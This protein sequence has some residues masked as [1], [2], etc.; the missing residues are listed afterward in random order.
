MTRYMIQMPTMKTTAKKI[1]IKIKCKTEYSL[2]T[3]QCQHDPD[4]LLQREN[5]G[6]V[7]FREMMVTHVG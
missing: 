1:T 3:L 6:K 4:A 5:K 2:S 7:K